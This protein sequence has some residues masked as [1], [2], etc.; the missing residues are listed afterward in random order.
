MYR[1]APAH[2]ASPPRMLLGSTRTTTSS[3]SGCTTASSAGASPLI[4]PYSQVATRV[5]TSIISWPGASLMR[6]SVLARSRAFA[7]ADFKEAAYA[8]PSV[9]SD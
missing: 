4:T 1:S 6:P 7:A 3:R 5:A 8:S 2:L 9:G